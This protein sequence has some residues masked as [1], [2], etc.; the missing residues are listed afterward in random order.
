MPRRA[1]RGGG[2]QELVDPGWPTSCW[3]R[4]S[5]QAEIKVL[6]KVVSAPQK[7]DKMVK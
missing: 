5:R 4:P 1:D 2:R 3:P 7:L 6:T